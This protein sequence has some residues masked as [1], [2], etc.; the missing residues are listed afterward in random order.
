MK[1]ETSMQSDRAPTV[2]DL[3]AG[4]PFF[5]LAQEINNLIARRAY[6]LFESS[7]SM[8]GHAREDWLVLSR[9]SCWTVP[10]DV[11]ETETELI[12]RAD[13]PGFGEKDL[14]VRVAPRSLCITGS[15]ARGV[16]PAG[17]ERPSIPNGAPH[18][19]SV[20]WTCR[21]KIDP[22][23]VNATV[24]DGILDIKLSKVGLGKKV[25]VLAKAAAA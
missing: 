3:F 5:E 14:E 23:R 10:V 11:T 24:S 12:V 22:D 4:D 18:R 20:C 2:H 1:N 13:V 8:H 9:K 17:R 19:S 15:A 25:P 6:E 16:G 21:V 7:G